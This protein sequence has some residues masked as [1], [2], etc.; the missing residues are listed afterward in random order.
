MIEN[1]GLL[2]REIVE[3]EHHIHLLNELFASAEEEDTA[4]EEEED[5]SAAEFIGYKYHIY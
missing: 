2:N 5:A 3:H 1:C 4:T